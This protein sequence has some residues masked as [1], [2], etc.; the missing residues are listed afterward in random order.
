MRV[1]ESVAGVVLI[2]SAGMNA[3]QQ[4]VLLARRHRGAGAWQLISLPAAWHFRI[5]L[6]MIAQGVLLL[7]T[8]S[9]AGYWAVLGLWSAIVAW[10][11]GIW[12]R[13][14]LRHRPRAAA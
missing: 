1:F 8:G 5:A 14:R 3:I 7:Q 12:L 11:C 2:V 4:L 10:H 6:L 9:S 13:T